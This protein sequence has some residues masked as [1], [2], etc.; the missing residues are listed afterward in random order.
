M[1]EYI[2]ELH[3]FHKRING[4]KDSYGAVGRVIAPGDELK[5]VGRVI[6]YTK[7]SSRTR[8]PLT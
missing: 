3:K 5:S 8:I 1:A 6:D 4:K 7:D 2:H